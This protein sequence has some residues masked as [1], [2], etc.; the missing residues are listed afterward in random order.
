MLD[1]LIVAVMLPLSTFTLSLYL[2][3][4]HSPSLPPSLPPS[5]FALRT[6]VFEEFVELDTQAAWLYKD[7]VA[8][9]TW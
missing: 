4:S 3:L 7:W 8:S 2:S 5:L 6:E 9:T 1:V